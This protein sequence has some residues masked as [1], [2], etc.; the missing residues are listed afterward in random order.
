MT[1]LQSTDEVLMIYL[2]ELIKPEHKQKRLINNEQHLSMIITADIVQFLF[3]EEQRLEKMKRN[4]LSY[5]FYYKA[6][7]LRHWIIPSTMV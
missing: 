7:A 4:S 5:T 6:R 3:N 2:R 1:H